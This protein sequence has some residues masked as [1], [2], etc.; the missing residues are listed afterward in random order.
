MA[1]TAPFDNYVS[2]YERWFNNYYFAYLS[3]VE[4]IRRS[5]PTER[6]GVEIGKGSDFFA[7]LLTHNNQ[8]MKF[9]V[10]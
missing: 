1:K 6:S 9:T 7:L 8:Y 2:K 10:F 3:A 5:L 4:A